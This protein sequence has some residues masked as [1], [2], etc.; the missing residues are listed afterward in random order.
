M[1]S[2]LIDEGRELIRRGRYGQWIYTWSH[3]EN[4]RDVSMDP[5]EDACYCMRI[6]YP[7]I[8]TKYSLFSQE[9]LLFSGFLDPKNRSTP[10]FSHFQK[11]KKIHLISVV[12]EISAILHA[13]LVQN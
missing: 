4:N 7:T 5:Q 2:D 8:P 1:T 12:Y 10:I 9:S 13:Y 3:P 6:V 11:K